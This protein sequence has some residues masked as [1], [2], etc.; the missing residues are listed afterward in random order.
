[1]DFNLQTG[2]KII[3]DFKP[4][5][6][7][8]YSMFIGGIFGSLIFFGFLAVWFGLAFG[9]FFGLEAGLIII[10]L[11][12]LFGIVFP[13]IG[14]ELTY[15]KRHYYITNRRIIIKRGFIGHTINSIPYERVSDVLISRSFWESLFGFGSLNVQ[16][17]AGQMTMRAGG[18]FGAEGAIQGIKN[19]ERLQKLIF[20]LITKNR[21]DQILTI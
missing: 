5:L 8:K 7:Y 2:E 21:K 10:I 6:S 4:M 3:E 15:R 1:M 18:K 16:S 12:V 19:P 9:A 17:L 13:I 11:I 14:A 20:D